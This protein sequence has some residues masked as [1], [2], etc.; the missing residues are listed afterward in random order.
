MP[1]T[2]IQ[3]AELLRSVAL[4][5]SLAPSVHN[6]QPW[7]FLIGPDWLEIRADWNRQLHALDPTGRQLLISCGCALFNARAAFAAAEADIDVQRF[8]DP[9][10]PELL[11]RIVLTGRPAEW[12]PLSR[13]SAYIES[14]QTNRRRFFPEEVPAELRYELE[15]AAE[16][17]EAQ[18]VEIASD[19]HRLALARLSQQADQLQIANPAYRAE[20]RAWTT[21]DPMRH[22]GVPAMAVPHVDAGS[23]DDI[24]LRD[25]DTRG[26]GWLPTVTHS[27]KD[28]CLLLLCGNGDSPEAWLRGGEALQR[29]WLEITRNAF[30]ATPLTQVVEVPRTRQALRDELGLNAH[31]YVLLRVGRAGTTPASRRRPLTDLVDFR[32]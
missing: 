30:V 17:E 12:N 23:E 16:A 31:P 19:E 11:A 1:E 2:A 21:D 7:R 24:P 29:V 8:P 13:L 26:M 28:Q 3:G 18:L 20:L 22:D 5:A 6:T 27:S 10:Q 9:S 4:K 32:R 15:L 25:F 14:R